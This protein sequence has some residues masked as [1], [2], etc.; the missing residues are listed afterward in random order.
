MAGR[1]LGSW[2]SAVAVTLAGLLL[3]A[4][5]APSTAAAPGAPVSAIMVNQVGYL[6]GGPKQA[7]LVTAATDPLPWQLVDATGRVVARGTSHPTGVDP[8]SGFNVHEIDIGSF[9]SIGRGYRLSSD[10]Q[11]SHPFDISAS[12]YERLR[13]DSLSFF[14]PQRS[15]TPIDGSIAGDA[16]ARDPGH[17]GVAPNLGDVA[18]PCQTAAASRPVYGEPWTCPYTL[19]VSG[20]WYDAGD[21]GKYVVNGGIAVHQLLSAWERSTRVATADRGAIGDGTL[22]IPERDNGRP[23]VLD[24]ARWELEWM[25]RMQVPVGQ[26]LAGMVHHKVHDRQ[27]TSAPL[28]PASS[29]APREL[30]RPSTAA[31]LN[32][33]SVAAQGAR[34]FAD[35]DAAFADRLLTAARIAWE[36]AV[37]HPAMLAPVDDD[38]G[39]G[40]YADDDVTDEFYWAATELF[41]TTGEQAYADAV[42]GNPLHT[43]EVFDTTGFYWGYVAPLARLDLAMVPNRLPDRERIE[44]SVLEAADAIVALQAAQPW[45]Q[46]YAPENHSWEWGSNSLILNNLI[47]LATA[48]D[49]S[50]QTAYRDAVLES[51]DY[52]LGRNANDISYV[53]GYGER[54]ARNQTSLWYANQ[55]DPTLPNPPPGAVAGGPNSRIQDPVAQDLLRGCAPQRCYVDDIGSWSTNEIAINWNSALAWV[56]SFVADQDDARRA[57]VSSSW[58]R[59]A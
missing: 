40:P 21:H 31:T 26:P 59:P 8:T 11:T 15:G 13:V 23:D 46:A 39:G 43:A 32:L 36:A 37:A 50:R 4:G 34:L 20:G 47:V 33:A 28:L 24:E 9:T 25:L 7:T 16:Y 19:D 56:V 3:A 27:W 54:F 57:A 1:R 14:Y 44:R 49:L 41:L 35:H 58:M 5:P 6:P 29:P 2:A 10:G 18:V 45:G 38:V 55:L 53:T 52:L 48:Y 42:L 17:L 22:R 30:H 51:M 12:A